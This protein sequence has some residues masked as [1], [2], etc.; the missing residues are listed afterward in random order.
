MKYLILEQ[1]YFE[2]I[3][4][5]QTMEALCC[6]RNEIRT[7][8]IRIERTHQLTA[9]WTWN[10]TEFYKIFLFLSRFLMFTSMKDMHKAANWNGKGFTSRDKL[11]EKLQS[12]FTDNRK[13]VKWEG[14]YCYQYD[15]ELQHYTNS[16]FAI[17]W[18]KKDV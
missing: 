8:N 3:E 5:S 13:I 2:L 9:Y 18:E 10:K 4:D 11:M 12:N 16:N 1:K 14:W 15:S 7:L 6:L 17:L